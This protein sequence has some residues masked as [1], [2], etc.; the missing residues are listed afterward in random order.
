MKSHYFWLS[1]WNSKLKK[2]AL[3]ENKYIFNY[4]TT[5][6]EC[7]SK[8]ELKLYV[9]E[10]CNTWISFTGTGIAKW[11]CMKKICKN[12]KMNKVVKIRIVNGLN[13]QDFQES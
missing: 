4:I 1:V 5:P 6:A 12:F 3:R 13:L 2:K 7:Q 8:L 9:Y 10:R 11:K